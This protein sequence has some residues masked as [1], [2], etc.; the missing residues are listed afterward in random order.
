VVE[1]SALL[2]RRSP[3]GYRGFESLPHRLPRNIACDARCITVLHN[4]CIKIRQ[5]LPTCNDVGFR[6][7]RPV[8]APRARACNCSLQ[9]RKGSRPRPASGTR[10]RV[11]MWPCLRENG[12]GGHQKGDSE[13]RSSGRVW[14]RSRGGDQGQRQGDRMLSHRAERSYLKRAN[15]VV[16]RPSCRYRVWL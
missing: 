5:C 16:N 12:I 9:S 13:Q 4:I 14:R 7:C 6:V 11:M 15:Q 8:V 1:S 3:K 10:S 2:K